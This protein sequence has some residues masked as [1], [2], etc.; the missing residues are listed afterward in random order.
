MKDGALPAY[1]AGAIHELIM[2][3][4]MLAVRVAQ[5]AEKAEGVYT[6]FVLWSYRC[7]WAKQAAI[8]E[9]AIWAYWRAGVISLDD[10][11]EYM[12]CL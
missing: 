9:T 4:I 10:R 1:T 7:D 5:A 6:D 3:D 2:K 8:A 12:A 11:D